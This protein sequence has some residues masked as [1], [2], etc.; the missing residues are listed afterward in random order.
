MP[1]RLQA[2][3]LAF[4]LAGLLGLG[5]AEATAA[6]APSKASVTTYRLPRVPPTG[7]AGALAVDPSGN[8]WFEETYESA[9]GSFPREV[10]RMN[11]AG[12]IVV[13]AAPDIAD[14]FAVAPDGSVW[15]TG[16]YKIGRIAP[17]GVVTTFPLPNGEGEEGKHVF[18]DGPLVIGSDGNVWFSGARGLPDEKGHVVGDEPIIGRLTPSGQLT[19][20]DL[21]RDGGH[22]IRL[23]AGPDGNV[24]FSEAQGHRISRI[25]PDGRIQAFSLAPFEEPRDLTAEPDGAIWFMDSRPD[26]QAIGRM[27]TSGSVSEFPLPPGEGEEPGGLYGA[28]SVLAGLDGRVWFVG[29]NGFVGRIGPTGRLSRVAIPTRNP[30]DLA[31]GPE[32]SIWYT[33][34]AEPPCLPGDSVCGQGGY[35]QSGVIGRIDPAPLSVQIESG[36][37]AADAHQVKVRLSC[38]DGSATSVCKGRLRLRSGR[39]VV[40]G[41]RYALGADL[42]RTFS[43]RLRGKAREKLLRT[44]HLRVKC[45]TTVAGGQA[46]VRA[47]RLRLRAHPQGA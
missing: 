11:R 12:E 33:S 39:A 6:V 3:A 32:G 9:P 30:E 7:G 24:W 26:G 17:D 31:L 23:T 19:E 43:L 47:L 27:T 16:F 44:G 20:F 22:P 21:P 15:F 18:D 41:R 4:A 25:S 8:V 46:G 29:E 28:G 40:A 2:L 38:L 1:V 5:G 10:V 37:P 35:Y 14:G 13:A 34:A 42:S 45:L 36:K